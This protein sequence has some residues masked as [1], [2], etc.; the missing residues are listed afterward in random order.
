MTL[1]RSA[2]LQWQ[3][4]IIN[5]WLNTAGIPSDARTEL[6]EMLS[7]VKRELEDLQFADHKN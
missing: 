1:L 6:I 7:A 5:L 4:E 3:E 2:E